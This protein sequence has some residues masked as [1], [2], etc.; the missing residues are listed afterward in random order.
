MAHIRCPYL[1]FAFSLILCIFA[2]LQLSTRPLYAAPPNISFA[3]GTS[4]I[5]DEVYGGA[6]PSPVNCADPV[7]VNARPTL[8]AQRATWVA[9]AQ[10]AIPDSA[11]L[12]SFV[13]GPAGTPVNAPLVLVQPDGF[14]LTVTPVDLPAAQGLHSGSN[15]TGA[16]SFANVQINGSPTGCTMQDNAPRPST[17]TGGDFYFNQLSSLHGLNGVLFTFSTPVQAFGAFLGDLE[18]SVR[19]TLAFMRLLDSSGQLI[20]DVPI[21]STLSITGGVAA[22]NAQCSLTNVPGAEVTAQG[23][24]PGCGN[25]STR[26]IGFVTTTPVAQALIVVGDNDPLPGGRGLTE[27]LSFMGPAVV[28]TLPP[29][30]VTLTKQAPASVTKG[31]PFYYTLLV[32]NASSAVAAGIV[33]TDSAPAGVTFNAVTGSGCTLASNTVNCRMETLAAGASISIQIQATANIT[34][35]VTNRAIV[36]ATND[37]DPTNNEA[38]VTI[39]PLAPAPLNYCAPAPPAG[40][41]PLIINEIAYR[42]SAS[43]GNDEWV[44]LYA[45]QFIAGG[46]SFYLSDNESGASEY[47]LAFT[48]PPGGIPPSTYIVVHR[49]AGANDTDA[50]DG[51]LQFYNTLAVSSTL[52]LNDAGDNL[53]LYQGTNNSGAVLDYVAYGTGSAVNGP[54]AGWST[55]NAPTGVSGG[56]SIALIRNGFDSSSGAEWTLAGTN[57]TQG[58]ATPGANNNA[59]T[60]CNVAISKRGPT[61]GVIG[62][63]F[64]YTIAVTNTTNVTMTGVVVTDTQPAGLIFNQITGP[65]CNLA[66]GQVSCALGV[67]TPHASRTI[68]VNATAN[69]A[70]TITNTAVTNAL[71]DTISMDNRAAQLTNFPALGS[72][73]D[74]VYYDANSN[75]SQENG[76]TT[77]LNGV[78]VTLTYP[79]GSFTTTVTVDGLYQFPNLPA[80]VYTVTVGAAPGY[81]RTGPAAYRVTLSAG[82]TYT[83]ADF[84]FVYQTVAVT[85]TK[86]GS[87]SVTVGQRFAYTLTVSNADAVA[88]ALD[89]ILT[90][91]Q[92]TGIQFEAV[93]D[94]RCGLFAGQVTCNL[95][96]LPVQGSATII[97]TATALTPGDWLNTAFSTASNTNPASAAFMTTARALTQQAD[98]SLVKTVNAQTATHG[99]ILTYTI[100]LTNLGPDKAIGVQV[101]ELL[102][103][104]LGYEADDPEQGGYDPNTG[105][106]AVGDVP[107]YSTVRLVIRVKVR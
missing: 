78:S 42:Q 43:N 52:K 3:G 90:D 98:L 33:V 14:S 79:N 77:P 100:A 84:G 26:W 81:V 13:P 49:I 66:S 64:N 87:A 50:S 99:D 32:S 20:A 82:Q 63:P 91:T 70:T 106:W 21:S 69:G 41:S 94:V 11:P 10:S 47:K 24:W 31:T 7:Y 15:A 51:V 101:T 6:G 89:V 40:G 44:E 71:S 93:Q 25:G 61:T 68:T 18:T 105:I 35:A 59:K 74:F 8:D 103:V 30:E 16:P 53:T 72:I 46:T 97:I 38:T 22:E 37:T 80:G 55:P 4:Y 57:N 27:R 19:G 5:G 1:R 86:Q 60:A 56:Q 67:L 92:P 29:A 62:A 58:P 102:P 2:W 65:G 48:I 34:G 39:N 88:P 76:E 36:S 96:S 9:S 73:G 12:G 45:T 85:L 54:G 23:L 75:G 95:G 28:R 104:T 83:Q 107:A 17:A